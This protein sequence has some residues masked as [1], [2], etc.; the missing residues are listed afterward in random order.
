MC[1]ALLLKLSLCFS[2]ALSIQQRRRQLIALRFSAL[3][4]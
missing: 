2:R 4:D 1:A 3:I